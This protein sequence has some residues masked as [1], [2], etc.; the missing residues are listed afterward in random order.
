MLAGEVQVRLGFA[1]YTQRGAVE[2]F[3]D[4]GIQEIFSK[5]RYHFCVRWRFQEDTDME[6]PVNRHTAAFDIGSRN[7]AISLDA[8]SHGQMEFL[9]LPVLA[10][11]VPPVCLSDSMRFSGCES[12]SGQNL[13]RAQARSVYHSHMDSLQNNPQ[14]AVMTAFF[15]RHTLPSSWR[16]MVRMFVPGVHTGD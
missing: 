5:G 15:S 10:E 3:E 13:A 12:C 6:I 14:Y 11:L 7:G 8:I 4:V 9:L 16:G 1:D 2:I